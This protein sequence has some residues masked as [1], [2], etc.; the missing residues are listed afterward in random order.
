MLA[1]VAARLAV[2]YA[3]ARQRV[4]DYLA[5]RLDEPKNPYAP[6]PHRFRGNGTVH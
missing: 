4:N 6:N 1:D 2:T 5:G 3:F